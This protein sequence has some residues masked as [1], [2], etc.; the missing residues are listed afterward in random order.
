[1]QKIQFCILLIL[2]SINLNGKVVFF[3]PN[4]KFARVITRFALVKPTFTIHTHLKNYIDLSFKSKK[5]REK[6]IPNK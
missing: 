3:C 1:M 6:K 4:D 2:I 5:K